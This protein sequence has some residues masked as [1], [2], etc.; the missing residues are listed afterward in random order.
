MTDQVAV[1]RMEKGGEQGA[2]EDS[3]SAVATTT[4]PQNVCAGMLEYGGTV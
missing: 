4:K 2:Q 1:V 3:F